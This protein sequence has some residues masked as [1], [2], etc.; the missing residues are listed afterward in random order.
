MRQKYLIHRVLRDNYDLYRYRAVAGW[1]LRCLPCDT[2][3]M[4]SLIDLW[5][6]QHGAMFHRSQVVA[7]LL[8]KLPGHPTWVDNLA[9]IE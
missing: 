3:T 4:M 1:S 7:D 9:L 8:Q 6:F 2:V 5:S